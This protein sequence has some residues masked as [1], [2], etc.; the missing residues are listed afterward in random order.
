MEISPNNISL[1]E[2]ESTQLKAIIT[3]S[4]AKDNLTWKSENTSIATVTSNGVVKAVK[5]G[6]VVIKVSTTNGLTATCKVNVAPL[7]TEVQLPENIEIVEGYHKTL[8]PVL[9]PNNS[10]TTYKWTSSNTSVA[11]VS[12]NGKIIAKQVGSADI[13]VTTKNN[14]TAVCRVTVKKAPDNLSRVK[15]DPKIN[16]IN[17][18][19]TNTKK[20]Y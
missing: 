8:I 17:N 20:Q 15:L 6:S 3:P 18:L 9:L 16:R 2:G 1:E 13:K 19:I 11:T 7:P 12:A 10:K 5:Q 4:E 14:K